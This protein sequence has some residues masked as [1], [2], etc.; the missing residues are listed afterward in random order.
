MSY[1]YHT[2]PR[3]PPR[4]VTVEEPITPV[5]QEDVASNSSGSS[6]ATVIEREVFMREQERLPLNS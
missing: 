3:T 6:I 5:L 4:T 1:E 2:Q